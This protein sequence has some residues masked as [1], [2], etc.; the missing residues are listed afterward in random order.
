MKPTPWLTAFSLLV[1]ASH[2]AGAAL[3]DTTWQA[4]ANDFWATGANWDGGLPGSG[5]RALIGSGDGK[6]VWLGANATAGGLEIGSGYTLTRSAAETANRTLNI[7]AST[8]ADN[9]FVNAG[10][11]ASGGASGELILNFSIGGSVYEN[12]GTITASNGSVVRFRTAANGS[13]ALNNTGGTLETSGT[14]Q[15]L[16]SGYGANAGFGGVTSITGGTISIGTGGSMATDG[17]GKGLDTL[18]NVAVTNRG[19]ISWVQKNNSGAS[20]TTVLSLGGTSTL[21]NYGTME[22]VRDSSLSI[23]SSAST[24]FVI[25]NSASFTNH[26]GA[27][28]SFTAKGGVS[29]TMVE[30]SVGSATREIVNDGT[31]TLE[32]QSATTGAWVTFGSGGVVTLGGTGELVLKVG[33]D[34]SSDMVGFRGSSGSGVNG[35]DHTIRGAG[36]IGDGGMSSFTNDGTIR[37]DAAGQALTIAMSDNPVDNAQTG[38]FTNNGTLEATGTA[39]L[40]LSRVNLVN[41]GTLVTGADTTF[42]T[43]SI[44]TISNSANHSIL[45]QGEWTSGTAGGGVIIN[46]GTLTYDS[47]RDSA[48]EVGQSGS[49]TFVKDGSG[50]LTLRGANTSTGETILNDGTLNVFTGAAKTMAVQ[51]VAGPTMNLSS[52][53]TTGLVMGQK[54]GSWLVIGVNSA[55]QFRRTGNAL[56]MGTS[57]T[58]LAYSTLSSGALTVNGGV[59]DLG[60][61]THTVAQVTVAGGTIRN[62]SLATSAAGYLGKSGEVSASLTGAGKTLTKQTAGTLLLTGAN[63][64]TGATSVEGGTLWVGGESGSINQTGSIS[65]S[66]AGSKLLYTSDVGLDRAVTLTGGGTFSYS[67]AVDYSGAFTFTQGRLGG[68][69]WSGSLDAQTIGAGQTIAPGNSVGVAT[70]TAQTWS[71]LGTYEW[72]INRADGVAG[73]P[74]GWDL[75][76]LGGALTL[77]LTSESRFTLSIVSLGL[78][79]MPGLATGFDPGVSYQWLMLDAG[80]E[81]VA[82][83][84]DWFAIDTNGFA[85]AFGGSFAVVQG[86]TRGLGGDA[87]QLYL[88]YNAVPEPGT[89][90]LLAVSFAGAALC[91]LRR[92]RRPE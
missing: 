18:T 17:V 3:T 12:S 13:V 5:S 11:I 33:T 24:R 85:N 1:L 73:G 42:R 61:G 51:N 2:P 45:I 76:S 52:G 87:S 82:F 32:S 26:E 89:W 68:T 38:L 25:G 43:G 6:T 86:G 55:T 72:E 7:S 37:A 60:E 92:V 10:N 46:D 83:S 34:G 23:H 80:E 74:E 30:W 65:V 58:A 84:E 29:N 28:L 56:P 15:L 40:A 27:S 21:D 54:I 49:G 70:G 20:S 9:R 16:F 71:G 67:S 63:S 57:V 48:N 90:A 19:L 64:Y 44:V 59:L 22:F 39:T 47:E 41:N 14:G 66:G 81:I 69:R 88:T 78:D 35:E 31:I 77:E 91:R 4:A 53:D 79:Q 8:A 36:S 50:S 75:L 62:G